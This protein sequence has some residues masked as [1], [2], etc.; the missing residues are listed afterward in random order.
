MFLIRLW[1]YLKRLCYYSCSGFG[2]KVYQYLHKKADFIMGYERQDGAAIVY[3][4]MSI[5]GFKSAR[6]AARGP[7]SGFDP[8]RRGSLPFHPIPETKR[9]LLGIR[10][11]HPHI[12]DDIHHLVH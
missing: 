9:F 11:C 6:S 3:M 4:K 10:V 8:R 5:H 12:P 1:H 7:A 2:R